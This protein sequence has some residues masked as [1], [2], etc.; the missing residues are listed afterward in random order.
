MDKK[1]WFNY[2]K[3]QNNDIRKYHHQNLTRD[4]SCD[5]KTQKQCNGNVVKSNT[6]VLE[7]SVPQP[8]ISYQST[9][10]NTVLNLTTHQ[11]SNLYI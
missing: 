2:K 8:T 11:V 3:T 9:T 10:E 4:S 5:C 1:T 6:S 7:E